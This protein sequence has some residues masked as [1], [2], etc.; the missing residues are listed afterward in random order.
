LC[1]FMLIWLGPGLF[2]HSVDSTEILRREYTRRY[3]EYNVK[4]ISQLHINPD[5]AIYYQKKAIRYAVLLKDYDVVAQSLLLFANAN[6][7]KG[8][9]SVAIE[10]MLQMVELAQRQSRPVDKAYAYVEIGNTYFSLLLGPQAIYYYQ[11]ALQL[12]VQEENAF[13]A[14]LCFNNIGETYLIMSKSGKNKEN[15]RKALEM[16]SYGYRIR[17]PLGDNILISQSLSYIGTCYQYLG[18]YDKALRTFFTALRLLPPLEKRKELYML[19]GMEIDLHLNIA[20]VYFKRNDLQNAEMYFRKAMDSALGKNQYHYQTVAYMHL[21]QL[22][23]SRGDLARAL[24][25]VK[26]SDKVAT[27]HNFYVDRMRAASELS[28]LYKRQ[29]DHGKYLEYA[30]VY[31]QL[32]DTLEGEDYRQKI[33]AIYQLNELHEQQTELRQKQEAV[34]YLNKTNAFEKRLRLFFQV[35][36]VLVLLLLGFTLYYFRRQAILN[37]RLKARNIEI[38]EKNAQISL[39]A[40]Q[41][42]DANRF[43]QL[44]LAVIGHDLR[45]LFQQIAANSRLLQ[46]ELTQ[47]GETKSLRRAENL[48]A[49]TGQ[50]LLLFENL[51]MWTQLQNEEI[52]V[53]KTDFPLGKV[54]D[55]NLVLLQDQIAD[56]KLGIVNQ[57]GRVKVHAD[58]NMIRTIVRNL[59]FNAIAHSG[60]EGVITAGSREENGMLAFYIRNRATQ[61]MEKNLLDWINSVP[62]TRSDILRSSA[63]TK[64]LGL[65][66]CKS[67]LQMNGGRMYARNLDSEVEIGFLIPAVKQEAE[68][69]P[70]PRPR[71]AESE[72]WLAGLQSSLEKLRAEPIYSAS[73]IF[74]LLER[75]EALAK[76]PDTW[77][78]SMQQAVYASDEERYRTLLSDNY[79]LN[80]WQPY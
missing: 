54:V 25:M 57:A 80:L 17:R 20:T 24:E 52:L 68:A 9:F 76:L 61:P 67:L 43:R 27:E 19:D 49:T 55:E 45:N 16:F 15:V 74:N 1:F 77:K 73:A 10:H 53:K 44:L 12:F 71:T 75:D 69:D 70:A 79:I 30:D 35:G 38:T 28:Q 14:G 13:G 22:Y 34:E 11:Q 23:K 36:V 33:G 8:E 37:R 7:I 31:H 2:A 6:R 26:E 63:R 78:K 59:L 50:A 51:I 65:M 72:Q 4:A 39:Y 58:E 41:L 48:S 29:G 42:S 40:S 3:N 47:S 18:D 5:S 32:K 66:I 64:G 21:A 46:D 56:R 60:T 62:D